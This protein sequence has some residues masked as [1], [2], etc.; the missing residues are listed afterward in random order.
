AHAR[1]VAERFATEHHELV[2]RPDALEVLPELVRRYGEPYADSSAVPSYYVARLTRDHVTVALDGDGGDELFAGYERY[3]AAALAA[4]LDRIPRTLRVAAATV[5]GIVPDSLSP[6]SP[7]RRARRFVRALPLEPRRRYLRWLGVFAEDA[8]EDFLDPGF[9]R[10]SRGG[11]A[12][13]SAAARLN[14]RD[15]VRAAQWIDMELYLPDDLLVK[16]DIAS[17]ANSLEVRC[18][19]LDHELVEFVWRLP[20]R[21]KIRRG[22]RK[23]L[24]KRAFDGIVPDENMYRR[25][26]GFALPIGSWMRAELAPYVERTVLSAEALDRGYFRPDR[27]RELVLDHTRGRADHTAKVWSLLMLE[28]WHREFRPA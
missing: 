14:G 7:M 16:M 18:P 24:L 26:Q 28:L 8:L 11:D 15:P 3:S 10:R 21:L 22:Q 19:F 17:M 20:T 6:T 5:A 1:R 2:V 27:V 13:P 25:K 4:S 23:W 9:E 12:V